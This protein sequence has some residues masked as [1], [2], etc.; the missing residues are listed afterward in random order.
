MTTPPPVVR[1]AWVPRTPDDAFRIFT[2]EI[3]AWWPLPTHGI[4]GD[5]SGGVVFADDRVVERSLSGEESVWA[6]VRVWEPPARLVLSWHPGRDHDDASEVEVNFHAD[7]DGTRVVLEHRGWE[8]FGADAMGRRRSYVGPNA[9]GHALDHFADGA[10]SPADRSELEALDAAYAMFFA[11]AETGGFGP[12]PAGEWTAAEVIAHVALNDLAMIGVCQAIV[13]GRTTTFANERCQDPAVLARWTT[14]A[15]DQTGL[16]DRGR[17][18]SRQVVAALAR[19]TP[20]QLA[21][22]VH[23]RLLHAGAVMLDGP[24][25]WGGVAIETQAEMHLP[26]HVGQLRALRP[27]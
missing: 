1:A 27:A 14:A 6:E 17:A 4:F 11:E 7:E 10:E 15:G 5:E 2:E 12:A 8:T 20:E 23:C 9:W 13:H 3:G 21:A 24:R 18:T 25:P 22:E 26:A 19:L 16:I